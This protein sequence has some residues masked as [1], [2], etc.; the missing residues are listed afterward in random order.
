MCCVPQGSILGPFLFIVYINDLKIFSNVSDA[1]I[2]ADDT[3]L[4][5]SE[6][7][8]NTLFTMANLE[9]QKMNEWLKANKLSL[10]AKK[11][12][13]SLYHKSTQKD[14]MPLALIILRTDGVELKGK[15]II[16]F[17]GV[18]LDKNLTWKD[19]INSIE[20]KISKKYWVNVQSKNVSNKNSLT[21]PFY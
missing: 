6:K 4:F 7:N 13:F 1:I 14:N 17:L 20:N 5:I 16:K 2:F 8:I 10:N 12:M 18:L 9:L 11:P 3:S 15:A 19:H 21:K